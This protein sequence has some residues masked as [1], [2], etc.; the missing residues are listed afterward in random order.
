MR[1]PVGAPNLRWSYGS[2]SH[3]GIRGET[4]IILRF[5]RRVV[6]GSPAG[7]A[8]FHSSSSSFS[9]SSSDSFFDY[10]NEEEEEEEEDDFVGMSTGRA[11]RASV[12]TSA[13][14]RASVR[15]HDIPPLFG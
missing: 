3:A 10:E 8:N 7:C 2:A 14:P 15:V 6:G 5:E 12:L 13:C 9:S 11:S 1:V 4:T